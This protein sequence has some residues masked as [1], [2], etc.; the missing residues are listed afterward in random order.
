METFQIKR[1]KEMEIQILH[2][3]EISFPIIFVTQ[4]PLSSAASSYPV[5]FSF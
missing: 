3:A 1:E 5:S 2:P 4:W